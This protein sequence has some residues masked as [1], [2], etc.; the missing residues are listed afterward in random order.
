MTSTLAKRGLTRDDIMPMAEYAAI[1]RERRQTIAE[2]KKRRRI[3][4]GPFATFYFENY[5]TMRHQVHEMLYVEKGGEA[6]I[7]DELTAYNPL[8]PQGN[9]LVA[10]VMLEIDDAARR[11]TVLARLGGIEDRIF[12]EV[13]GDRIAGAPDQTRENTSP[14]GKASSVQFVWFRFT[15]EQVARFRSPSARVIVGFDHPNY[16]HMAVM[17]E[18]VRSALAEDF[19]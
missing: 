3:E 11:A 9:E 18:L 2:L 4:V 7:A 16:A 6:Q 15:P 1:R 10:T 5:E 14:D 19:A 12:L 17:P 13:A 8:I